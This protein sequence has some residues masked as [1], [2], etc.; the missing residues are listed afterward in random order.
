MPSQATIDKMKLQFP[1][2]TREWFRNQHDVFTDYWNAKTGQDA[3]KRD[4][5]ATWR[6]WIRRAALDIPHTKAHNGTLSGVDAKAAGWQAMKGQ[7]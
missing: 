2:A 1:F 6:N 5:D 3:T 4:W 7:Q